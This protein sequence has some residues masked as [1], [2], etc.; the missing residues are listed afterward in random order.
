[1]SRFLSNIAIKSKIK[2]LR[3]QIL[4][5]IQY[6]ENSRFN[7]YKINE[8][9]ISAV[10]SKIDKLSN[11]SNNLTEGRV[12]N[13][14][15]NTILTYYSSNKDI[16]HINEYGFINPFNSTDNVSKH[17]TSI[18]LQKNSIDDKEPNNYNI[19]SLKLWNPDSLDKTYYK[20]G[21][22][23]AGKHFS[24]GDIV[25]I[26]P[27]RYV[28]GR[29]LYSKSIRNISFVIEKEQNIYAIPFGK[30]VFYKNSV[31][32]RFPGNVDYEFREVLNDSCIDGYIIIK[33]VQNIRKNTELI[34]KS[35]EHDFINVPVDTD[36]EY[37]RPRR[38]I[39]IEDIYVQ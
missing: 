15:L 39:I 23:Y 9:L 33:A 35:D 6:I 30:A 10:I 16:E 29:D 36:F 21:S 5:D 38:E 8:S 17:K 13:S 28:S 12:L 26:C 34:L 7:N 27:T 25:E 20:N 4:D 1:M 11:L 31:E 19:I 24:K 22:I 3:N 18:L 2:L 32:T 14:V 37:I